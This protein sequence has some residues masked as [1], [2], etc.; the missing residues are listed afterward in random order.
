ME[1]KKRRTNMARGVGK[2][3]PEGSIE[4]RLFV[5]D[6]A[7]CG[8]A[9]NN[10]GGYKNLWIIS[11][12]EIGQLSNRRLKRDFMFAAGNAT[13]AMPTCFQEC[14]RDWS[15]DFEREFAMNASDFYDFPFHPKVLDYAQFLAYCR[16]ADRQTQCF[17]ERCGDQSADRVFSPSN[18]LCSFKRQHF[19]RVRPCLEDSEPISFLRCDQKCHPAKDAEDGGMARGGGNDWR[20]GGRGAEMGKVFSGAEMDG[21]ERELDTLC[22]FQHCYSQCQEDIATQICSPGQAALAAEL[23]RT[24]VQ[25]HSADL[26][27]WHILTGNELLLPKSC[28]KLAK[29]VS[30]AK[31]PDP[32]LKAM[33]AAA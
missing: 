2:K 3:A 23:V 12:R 25:W 17:I 21:Y 10:A 32:V 4:G 11:R 26:L 27:D 33:L 31:G 22:A 19:L 7:N 13:D 28:T 5:G 30:P 9:R 15:A 1:W 6:G 18:F 29:S 16:L 14:N 24:Y 20:P 8:K